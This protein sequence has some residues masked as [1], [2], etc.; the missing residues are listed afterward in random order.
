MYELTLLPDLPGGLDFSRAYGLND[1]GQVIGD[2]ETGGGQRAFIW[3]STNG[4]VD[5]GVLANVSNANFSVASKITNDGVIVGESGRTP[6]IGWDRRVFTW[7][8]S[9]GMVDV[10]L[11]HPVSARD[12]N[13]Q[14]IIAGSFA[15]IPVVGSPTTSWQTI[16]PMP[17]G[18]DYRYSWGINNLNH[19]V[20]VDVVGN[21]G[22]DL[23]SAFL[24]AFH[25]SE[26]TGLQ[27]LPSLLGGS[28]DAHA[29]M[30]NDSGQIVGLAENSVGRTAVLWDSS[31]GIVDLGDLPGGV[32]DAV[33]HDINEVGQIVGFGAN[34]S[35]YRATF[36]NGN[37]GPVDLNN[38]LLNPLPGYVLTDARG[39][40]SHGQIV[41]FGTLNDAI[42]RGFLLT[43]I[44]DPIASTID[45]RLDDFGP[46]GVLGYRFNGGETTYGSA[47]QFQFDTQNPVGNAAES[48]SPHAVG[49]CIELTQT[50]TSDFITYN[51]GD[52]TT[53]QDPVGVS[54]TISPEQAAL[55]EQL[56]ALHYDADWPGSGP[57]SLDDITRSMAFSALLYEI[58]YDFDGVS[59]ASLDLGS[60]LFEL[61]DGFV[62]DKNDPTQ[63]LP[64]FD[65]ASF[66]LSTLSLNYSGPRPLLLALTNATQ[67]DYL[68]AVVP[69]VGTFSL[70]SALVTLC[71]GF[72]LA[73]RF[74]TEAK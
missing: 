4:M 63:E 40:N 50:F 35:G 68:V 46:S 13:E 31:F 72:S 43:P 47:G 59:L 45:V 56:W 36:W 33:A 42:T 14:G 66:F 21:V 20:G 54:G 29:W 69:E 8:A 15:N 1:L 74:R 57:F 27:Y 30:I 64:V 39:I 65:V 6:D 3:D 48:V 58:I 16:G 67:Q 17:S 71:V 28:S 52:V 12:I 34:A 22:H 24:R 18:N 2:S 10:G 73:R 49:F 11:S 53:A 61:V 38:Q 41:G 25:W 9:N 44:P 55:I 37:S 60:G 70:M 32:E 51:V 26:S 19:V 5:L 23:S 7:K 62:L